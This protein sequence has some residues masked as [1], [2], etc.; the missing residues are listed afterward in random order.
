M[1]NTGVGD[2]KNSMEGAYNSLLITGLSFDDKGRLIAHLDKID[3]P[4]A[5]ILAKSCLSLASH[6]FF[7]KLIQY[8]T[9][10]CVYFKYLSSAVMHVT[11]IT[12]I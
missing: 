5:F 10:R 4:L 3:L 7:V 11:K 6:S 1:D 12:N 2:S 8:Q 9:K